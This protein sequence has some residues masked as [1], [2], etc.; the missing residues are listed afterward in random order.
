MKRHFNV[1]IAVITA[2]CF[3]LIWGGVYTGTGGNIGLCIVAVSFSFILV[4][5]LDMIITRL[6][7]LLEK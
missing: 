1:V 7:K 3:M 4:V 2:I 6:D 5:R